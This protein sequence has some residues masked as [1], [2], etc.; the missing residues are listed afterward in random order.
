MRE[1]KNLHGSYLILRLGFINE[2]G[3][4]LS[5]KLYIIYGEQNRTVMVT[6][7]INVI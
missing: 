1:Q 3:R 5:R 6:G 4:S 7:F 2:N